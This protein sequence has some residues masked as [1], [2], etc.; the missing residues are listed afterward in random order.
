[1]GFEAVWY[2]IK[3]VFTNTTNETGRLKERPKW[4]LLFYYIK[5]QWLKTEIQNKKFKETQVL[6]SSHIVL[7][8]PKENV[9]FTGTLILEFMFWYIVLV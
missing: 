4:V 5:L 7:Y 3:V 1:M 8:I 2:F 6:L 9:K